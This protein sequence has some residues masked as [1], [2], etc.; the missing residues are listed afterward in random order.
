MKFS[1]SMKRR[2]TLS[3]IIVALL[4]TVLISS[5]NDSPKSSSEAFDLFALYV[6]SKDLSKANK[7]F[8]IYKNET[9]E[10][11]IDTIFNIL[12]IPTLDFIPEKNDGAFGIKKTGDAELYFAC[13]K[14]DGKVFSP[15]GIMF[16]KNKNR[17]QIINITEVSV[18]KN[19]TLSEAEYYDKSK[20]GSS[21][22]KSRFSKPTIIEQ[23]ISDEEQ[24]I[25]KNAYDLWYNGYQ[26][27]AIKLFRVFIKKYPKSFLADDSQRMIALCYNNMEDYEQ[28]IIE[29]NKVLTQYPN[30]NSVITSLYDMAHLN[31]YYLND[32]D[33]AKYYY[34]E[35]VKSISMDEENLTEESIF[36][37]EHSLDQLNNWEKNVQNVR[38]HPLSEK[39]YSLEKETSTGPGINNFYILTKVKLSNKDQASLFVKRLRA[40]ARFN[41]GNIYIFDDIEALKLFNTP[42]LFKKDY[43]YVAEHF[44]A[45]STFDATDYIWW[46]PYIDDDYRNY[47][48]TKSKE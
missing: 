16:Q 19:N 4:I 24:Q 48:G 46:F 42:Q 15:I 27:D 33:K 13:L 41:R 9:F 8:A 14:E 5:C 31:F 11:Y 47:G 21:G 10:S 29:Y 7:L 39:E 3:R 20:L 17:Y 35:C 45:M 37:R 6:K 40:H 26:I 22:K 2:I 1:I 32:F 25:Y 23:E 30:S 12:N 44:M 43:I 36:V 38:T 18:S 28:A 34:Q